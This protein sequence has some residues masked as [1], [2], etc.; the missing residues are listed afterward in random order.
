MFWKG[1]TNMKH[2]QQSK[3]Q[4]TPKRK[5]ARVHHRPVQRLSPEQARTLWAIAKEHDQEA[6]FML[7]LVLGLRSRELLALQWQAIN[8]ES[9]SLWV[10]LTLPALWRGTDQPLFQPVL[11]QRMIPSR[12]EIACKSTLCANG[13]NESLSECH[14]SH[15]T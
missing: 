12:W 11:R 2:D 10:R 8:W 5:S 6:L 3:E 9:G 13:K 14:G 4:T 15:R 7:A 1:G